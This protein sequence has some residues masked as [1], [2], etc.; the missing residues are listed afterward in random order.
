MAARA[1]LQ[2]YNINDTSFKCFKGGCNRE[3]RLKLCRTGKNAQRRYL[4][5]DNPEHVTLSEDARGQP[6]ELAKLPRRLDPISVI[7]SEFDYVHHPPPPTHTAPPA[8]TPSPTPSTPLVEQQQRFTQSLEALQ[9]DSPSTSLSQTIPTTFLCIS[10]YANN[11]PAVVE[12]VQTNTWPTWRRPED[13][14]EYVFLSTRYR[15]W[16]TVRPSSDFVHVLSDNEP[17]FIRCPPDVVGSN[18]KRQLARLPAPRPARKH[19]ALR[20]DDDDDD[21]VVLVDYHPLDRARQRRSAHAATSTSYP[22]IPSPVSTSKGKKCALDEDNDDVVVVGYIPAIKHE[23]T[24]LPPRTR[25]SLSVHI[26]LFCPNLGSSSES[27]LP[28]LSSSSSSAVGPSSLASPASDDDKIPS[29]VLLSP[30]HHVHKP[31]WSF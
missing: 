19:R 23:L 3:L 26:P 6:R 31:S 29:T 28:G 27:S 2:L 18:E 17:L 25:P 22:S 14:E 21:E 1:T 7:G 16:V 10:W 15:E 11:K 24:S 4:N 13:G 30:A 20:S 8:P 12:G 9:A 5:C